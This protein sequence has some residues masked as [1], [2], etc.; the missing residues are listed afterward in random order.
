M[1]VDQFRIEQVLWGAAGAAV[2][3]GIGLLAV[4]LGQ[5]NPLILVL[6]IVACAAAGVL[7]RDWW[8][9]RGGQQAGRGDHRR[10]P[11]DRRDAGAG[12]DRRRE[13]DRRDRPDHPA[14]PGPAGQPARRGAGRDPFRDSISRRDHPPAGPHPAGAAG[15][16]PRRHGRRHRTRHATG[17]RAA[18]AGRRRPG[19]RQASTARIRR[20][21]RNRHDGPGGF[22]RPARSPSFSPCTR[23]CSRSPRSPNDGLFDSTTSHPVPFT[24][25][26]TDDRAAPAADRPRR[27]P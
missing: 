16:L 6:L 19:A 9:S 1:T 17:R 22:H 11:G 4:L 25:R 26:R 7:G 8:L 2:G 5:S 12:G 3:A 18:G 10:V 20:P 21:Q 27:P 13:P 24:A 15:P 23:A 14:R